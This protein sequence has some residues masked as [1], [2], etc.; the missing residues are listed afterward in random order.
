[1]VLQLV[2]GHTAP[3]VVERLSGNGAAGEGPS[4]AELA[5]ITKRLAP[6]W[7]VVRNVHAEPSTVLLQP[8]WAMSFLRGP[9]TASEI[10]RARAARVPAASNVQPVS[11]GDDGLEEHGVVP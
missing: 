4:S 9:M 1:M 6:R 8:R 5:Q 10:R 11:T 3:E 7:F 2:A